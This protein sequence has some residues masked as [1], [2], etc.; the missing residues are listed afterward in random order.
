MNDAEPWLP[1]EAVARHLDLAKDTV[2]RR[3]RNK[4]LPSHR[5]GQLPK[6]RPSEVG[7]WIAREWPDEMCRPR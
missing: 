6:L 4:G 7:A 5:L 2:D 1:A 3:V